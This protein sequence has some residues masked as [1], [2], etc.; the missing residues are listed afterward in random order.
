[1]SEE[2]LNTEQRVP[3]EWHEV[4]IRAVTKPSLATFEEILQNPLA[5][6]SRAYT[7][8]FVTSLISQLIIF[9]G[10][11]LTGRSLYDS[12]DAWQGA[13]TTIWSLIC[14]PVSA[15]VAVLGFMISVG[16]LQWI[17]GL[18]GGSGR[19]DNL[20]VATAAYQAPLAAVSAVLGLLGSW[21]PFAVCLGVPLGIYIL[22]LQVMAVKA[23]NGFSW[24]R[25]VAT[26]LIPMGVLILIGCVAVAV[27]GSA[28]GNLFEAGY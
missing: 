18:L 4:W 26:L 28:L 12:L 6:T 23:V 17:A 3:L 15:G 1:M 2:R 8:I 13:N 21:V 27:L 5:S 19:Y 10:G 25:A 22:V 9:A 11:W 16:I 24:E 20:V 14:S 7:W